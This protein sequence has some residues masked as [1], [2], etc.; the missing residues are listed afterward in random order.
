M[1]SDDER[2]ER[3]YYM[4]QSLRYFIKHPELMVLGLNPM[5]HILR[6]QLCKSGVIYRRI[7]SLKGTSIGFLHRFSVWFL[8]E[9]NYLSG[10]LNLKK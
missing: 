4:G 6:R 1:I 10:I 9:Y 5:A 8:S 3:K 7:A 2:I